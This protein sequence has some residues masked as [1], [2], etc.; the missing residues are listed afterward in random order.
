LFLLWTWS[1]VE[2][3]LTMHR[4]TKRLSVTKLSQF[5]ECAH[6]IWHTYFL[7]FLT[8]VCTNVQNVNSLR[9]TNEYLNSL[10]IHLRIILT[11]KFAGT[12]FLKLFSNNRIARKIYSTCI[13]LYFI[14]YSFIILSSRL[15]VTFFISFYSNSFT[16]LYK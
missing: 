2:N 16:L 4:T 8:K 1:T 3:I 15:A 11:N 10:T 12:F 6:I 13:L 7:F 5:W 9:L 14:L